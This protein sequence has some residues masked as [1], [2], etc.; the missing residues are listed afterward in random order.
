MQNATFGEA[1]NTFGYSSNTDGVLSKATAGAHAAV[2]SV[3]DAADGAASRV[4][5]AIDQVAAMAHQ[6]VENTAASAAPATDW[7]GEQVAGL[8]A[9]ERKLVTETSAYIA[10]NPLKSVG[11]AVLAGFLISRMVRR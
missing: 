3:A 5:P 7:L 4:K 2:N 6:V 10:T 11:L 1:P 8:K 9:S